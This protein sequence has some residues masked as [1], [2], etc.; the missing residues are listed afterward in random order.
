[1]QPEFGDKLLYTQL[2]YFDVMFDEAEQKKK[3]AGKMPSIPKSHTDVYS[4][5]KKQMDTELK[6][7]GYNYCKLPF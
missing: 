3:Y 1:M 4:M 2:K 7:C 6:Q 5:L